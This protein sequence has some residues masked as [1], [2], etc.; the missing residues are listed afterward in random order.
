MELRAITDYYQLGLHL[1]IK[2][3]DLKKIEEGYVNIERRITEV[4]SHWQDNSD[5][6]S[7]EALAKAVEKMGGHTKVVKKLRALGDQEPNNTS[8]ASQI[9]EQGII[10][11]V[12][13]ISFIQ[14]QYC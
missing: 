12:V 6:C 10:L 5:D 8:N 11:S 4:I 13:V 1:G 7:W 3:E 14:L 2:K 9:S